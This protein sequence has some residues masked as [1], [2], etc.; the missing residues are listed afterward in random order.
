MIM[1]FPIFRRKK[2]NANAF[3]FPFY[4]MQFYYEPVTNRKFRSRTEVMYYLEHGTPKKKNKKSVNNSDTKSQVSS[5]IF[6]Y[7]LMRLQRFCLLY[8][9]TFFF[10]QRSEDRGSYKR[11]TQSNKKANE[12]PPPSPPPMPLDFDFLN[13]P[14][15]VIWTGT[16][17]LQEAWCPFIGDYKI[18]ESVSQDWDRAFTLLTANANMSVQK[19]GSPNVI[20]RSRD[21][22]LLSIY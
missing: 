6:L 15:K 5:E 17:G 12:Q 1:L 2:D 18:Q 13:V 21:L 8:Y 3:N 7:F 19:I 16:N 22:Y 10:L 14:E 9:L 11:L 4:V 20:T